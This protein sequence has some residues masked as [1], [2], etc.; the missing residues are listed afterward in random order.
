MSGSHDNSYRYIRTLVSSTDCIKTE[1]T[2][3]SVA[4]AV[5]KQQRF[6]VDNL[7]FGVQLADILTRCSSHP[8]GKSEARCE[9]DGKLYIEHL[10]VLEDSSLFL[11]TK[12]CWQ[13]TFTCS[14][15][16][17]AEQ[18]DSQENIASPMQSST[19]TQGSRFCFMPLGSPDEQTNECF[20]SRLN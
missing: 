4:V 1:V 17:L 7:M 11:C 5:N 20:A 19:W 18:L 12:S 15:L 16:K 10:V 14:G 2:S 8:Q 9:N 13:W 3:L 6:F